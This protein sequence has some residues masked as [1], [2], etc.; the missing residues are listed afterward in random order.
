MRLVICAIVVMCGLVSPCFGQRE[1][2]AVPVGTVKA[3]RRSIAKTVDFVGRV[4]AINHVEIT[5][6]VQ[7]FLEAVLF[8]EGDPVKEGDP[9]YHIEK[10]QFQA[11]VEQAQG[12]LARSKAALTLASLQRQRAQEL[13]DKNV[14]TVVARDQAVA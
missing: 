7:G 2:A 8:K 9:L 10:D 12:I 5:A 1:P 6:R 13:L 11:A 3:E 14:G 4:N